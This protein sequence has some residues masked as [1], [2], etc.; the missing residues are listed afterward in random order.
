M[1]YA[2]FAVESETCVILRQFIEGIKSQNWFIVLIEVLVV[3]VGI[4]IGLQVDDW[5]EARKESARETV[6][7]QRLLADTEEMI[8]QHEAHV[9]RAH[10]WIEAVL[11]SLQALR[12]CSLKPEAE[13][14]F[15][16]T[17]L[18]HQG[19]E[20]LVVVRASYDEMVASGALARIDDLKLKNKIS[21]VF[22]QAVIAQDFIAY[23]TNDLGR[24]SDIIW[25]H[26]SFAIKADATSDMN[27]LSSWKSENYTQSVTYDFDELCRNP[28]F[29]NA[30][31]EVFDS[32]KDRL[33]IG[34]SF[35]GEL[36]VLHA[37]LEQRL[38]G[39]YGRRK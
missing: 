23:F 1:D 27:E 5:N 26:V 30:I 39:E 28:T 34:A 36:S 37:L 4:I 19:L 18:N 20:R 25:R 11:V 31:V 9:E 3:V 14:A 38:G 29:K 32:A 7:L 10:S 13:K 17:L 33:G 22:S 8:T 24:A 16:L 2:A 21:G 12:S 15:E 35:A 6:Y